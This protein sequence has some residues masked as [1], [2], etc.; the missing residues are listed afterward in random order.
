MVSIGGD[1]TRISLGDQAGRIGLIGL[2][3]DGVLTLSAP[4][5]DEASE[6]SVRVDSFG[7][8]SMELVALT[9]SIGVRFEADG[10][11]RAGF[12]DVALLDGLELVA[13]MPSVQNL[14]A[15]Y[16]GSGPGTVT[17]YANATGDAWTDVAVTQR[18]DSLSP[19]ARLA[20]GP[21]TLDGPLVLPAD[22][23][24]GRSPLDGLV[25][26]AITM[27]RD[28]PLAFARW[29]DGDTMIT[30]TS[31]S[32]VNDLALLLPTLRPAS[33]TEWREALRAGR[34]A[35][36]SAAG[37][38]Q[39]FGVA[40]PLG[41]GTLPTGEQ[42]HVTFQQPDELTVFAP[43]VVIQSSMAA[44]DRVRVDSFADFTLVVGSIDVASPAVSMRVTV[45][46]SVAAE[47]PLVALSELD[48]DIELQRKVCVL[49]F[50]QLGA[51]T[52]DFLDAGGAVV[53]TIPSKGVTP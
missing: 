19:V 4:I 8:S 30:V 1:A 24:S 18:D 46:G 42:W 29:Y 15:A 27:E 43:N 32:S 45:A 21:P 17:A 22:P 23:S 2:Q 50:D 35:A 38:E 10:Q 40:F 12:S 33:S 37:A 36:T 41:G 52:V 31:T 47:L 20:L 7:L 9:S 51:F 48:P 11:P 16:V 28:E 13:A 6:Y 26:G 34:R 44:I 53:D 5:G 49:F 14:L 3:P 39:P 25:L